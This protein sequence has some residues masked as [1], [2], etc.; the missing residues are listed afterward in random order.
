MLKCMDIGIYSTKYVSEGF[1]SNQ[2]HDIFFAKL[3]QRPS[4]LIGY[5]NY[6]YNKHNHYGN[7]IRE[8]RKL[9]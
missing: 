4:K 9:F 1:F 8:G 7:T 3:L 6:S 2:T 5:K